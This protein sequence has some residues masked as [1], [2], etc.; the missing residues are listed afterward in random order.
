M[1]STSEPTN[2]ARGEHMIK[3]DKA[4]IKSRQLNHVAYSQAG[5]NEVSDMVREHNDQEMKRLEKA[6]DN[7]EARLKE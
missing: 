1:G 7:I 2:I 3:E 4:S 6:R 5:D